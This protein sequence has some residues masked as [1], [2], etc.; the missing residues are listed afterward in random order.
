ML[1]PGAIFAEKIKDVCFSAPIA[2][3]RYSTSLKEDAHA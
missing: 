2:V 1:Q 3:R